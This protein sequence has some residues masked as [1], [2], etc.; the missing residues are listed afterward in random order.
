MG[1][2]AVPPSLQKSQKDLYGSNI[3]KNFEDFVRMVEPTTSISISSQVPH[4][5]SLCFSQYEFY[6]H[7]MHVRVDYKGKLQ[8]QAIARD[9]RVWSDQPLENGGED[10]GMTPP[11]WF[12]ASLGSC[13]GFYA[14]KYCQTRALDASGLKI[15][16]SAEKMTDKPARLDN[17][18]IQLTLPLPLDPKHYQG[19]RAAVDSCLIENTLLHSPSITTSISAPETATL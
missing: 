19:L 2:G 4:P 1:V 10:A 6:E 18:N 13:V 9:H 14:V 17:I 15:D 5:L 7:T 16:V 12:L 11:E 8:F 3:T